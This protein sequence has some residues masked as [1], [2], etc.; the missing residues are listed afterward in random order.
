MSRMRGS[1]STTSTRRAGIGASIAPGGVFSRKK[2]NPLRLGILM[3]GSGGGAVAEL[4]DEEL[5]HLFFQALELRV[6]DH[7]IYDLSRFAVPG[8]LDA[9]LAILRAGQAD[10]AFPREQ[11]RRQIGDLVAR[12][13]LRGFLEK[14]LEEFL[15]GIDVLEAFHLA[16][17]HLGLPEGEQLG[18]LIPAG[19]ADVAPREL[20][21]DLRDTGVEDFFRSKLALAD[22]AGA[23]AL[24]DL[25]FLSLRR[26]AHG[27]DHRVGFPASLTCPVPR[28]LSISA[29]K[30]SEGET[31]CS[32]AVFTST[33][34]PP[35][36]STSKKTGHGPGWDFMTSWTCRI[37]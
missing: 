3:T 16:A 37:R 26:V 20:A 28:M 11:Q 17:G 1:S 36:T 13:V 19:D 24:R 5:H 22:A 32:L 33:F 10:A 7:R 35:G 30:R 8:L 2:E 18:L 21:V 34:L 12:R 31:K 27:R 4:D 29:K 23:A 14:L 15:H 25:P 9:E 6:G